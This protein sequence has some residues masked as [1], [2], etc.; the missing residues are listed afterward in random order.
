MSVMWIERCIWSWDAA[1]HGFGRVSQPR[2]A[3][4]CGGGGIPER[5][6]AHGSQA[7]E[8]GLARN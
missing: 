2:L 8:G 6:A 3:A 4:L 7:G 1:A 5:V